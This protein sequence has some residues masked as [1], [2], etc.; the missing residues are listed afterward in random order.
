MGKSVVAFLEA[1]ETDRIDV[2]SMNLW[3]PTVRISCIVIVFLAFLS[4]DAANS[5]AVERYED[6]HDTPGPAFL[7][8]RHAESSSAWQKIFSFSPFHLASS[9]PRLAMSGSLSYSPQNGWGS[10]F[11]EWKREVRGKFPPFW[12]LV[13][14]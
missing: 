13:G 6:A 9:F 1:N 11:L 5:I 7:K 12:L 4:E 3:S 10:P 8:G 14:L 2:L